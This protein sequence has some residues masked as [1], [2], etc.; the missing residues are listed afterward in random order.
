MLN[1]KLSAIILISLC[2]WN[3]AASA[4]ADKLD[5]V[6]SLD[7]PRDS[8]EISLGSKPLA[9]AGWAWAEEG[10]ARVEVIWD[11]K[12]VAT[13]THGFPRSDVQKAYPN[14]P[15]MENTGYNFELDG[16][17][18]LEGEH[19]L[20]VR[21]VTK[22]NVVVDAK[23]IKVTLRKAL[24]SFGAIEAPKEGTVLNGRARSVEL[25]GWIINPNGLKT[26]DVFVNDKLDG[27]AKVT[28]KRL[29][30]LAICP[31][32][33]TEVRKGCGFTYKLETRKLNAGANW[34][35]VKSAKSGNNERS[36][37]EIGRVSV[38]LDK[39]SAK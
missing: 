3:G 19:R 32:Y 15:G 39:A 26:A 4:R 5:P 36:A 2:L 28:L 33:E 6:I 29:D 14:T 23:P 16:R 21:L 20:L 1:N 7:A 22:A 25:T 10:V 34:I 18:S 30:V 24:A 13:A 8:A 27:S 9:G 31:A 37:V 11:E 38:I 17:C 35:V 12:V